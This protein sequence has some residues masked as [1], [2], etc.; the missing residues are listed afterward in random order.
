MQ[1]ERQLCYNT[2]MER[3]KRKE[4]EAMNKILTTLCYLE[5]DGRYLMLNRTKKKNDMNND[6]YIWNRGN[7]QRNASCGRFWRKRAI[8]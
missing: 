4:D 1:P 5:K 7:P 6:K 2:S 8:R 3:K